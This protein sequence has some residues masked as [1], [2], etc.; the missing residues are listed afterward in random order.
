MSARS[1]TTRP[2]P[3]AFDQRHHAVARD[4][5][6]GL[7]AERAQP[8]CDVGRGL[9]LAVRQLGVLMEVAAPGDEVRLDGGAARRSSSADRGRRCSRPG[10]GGAGERRRTDRGQT[11]A[12]PERAKDR[13]LF[14]GRG[15]SA[16]GARDGMR[17]PAHLR[18]RRAPGDGCRRPGS[19]ARPGWAW[20]RG[21][22]AN[23]CAAGRAPRG[24]ATRG[25]ASW[26]ASWP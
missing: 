6:L 11:Q 15:H 20:A 10:G 1:A 3:A 2:R 16:R 9:L 22:L 4:A 5:G 7:Q 19:R 25:R 14:H 12:Q 18:G 21:P 24:T 26:A 23:G 8:L 13:V 17:Y